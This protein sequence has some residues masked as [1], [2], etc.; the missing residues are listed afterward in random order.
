MIRGTTLLPGAAVQPMWRT[1]W[2]GER[3]IA[4]G[5]M[6]GGGGLTGFGVGS[7]RKSISTMKSRVGTVKKSFPGASPDPP[8]EPA[9]MTATST[10]DST[11]LIPS[12]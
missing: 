2:S 9:R 10:A 1:V 8:A 5:A 11:V 3:P 4:A 7:E 6:A 12:T